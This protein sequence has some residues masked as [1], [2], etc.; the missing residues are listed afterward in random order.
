MLVQFQN[1]LYG[2]MVVSLLHC[3]KFTKSLTDVGFKINPYD[4]CVANNMIDGQQMTIF[5]HVEDCKLS[6]RRSKVT[7]R[8]IKWLRQEYKSIFEYGS[9]KMEVSRGKVHKYLGMTLDYTVRGQVKITMIDFLDKFLTY[10][11]KTEPK[12][13]GKKTSA[14]PENLFNVDKYFK[15][16][17]QSKTVQFQK[18]VAKTLYGTK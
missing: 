10:F 13:G 15:K 18:L 17:P 2:M 8:M 5:Y 11:G 14:A 4:P 1:A 16:L 6:H 7:D 9:G 3:R 12:G